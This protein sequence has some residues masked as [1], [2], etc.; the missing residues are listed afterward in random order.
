MILVKKQR[1][2]EKKKVRKHHNRMKAFKGAEETGAEESKEIEM[3]EEDREQY[4]NEEEEEE[5]GEV[6]EVA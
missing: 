6:E 4:L 5:V 3:Y 2:P 1:D